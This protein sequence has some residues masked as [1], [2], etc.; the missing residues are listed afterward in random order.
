MQLNHDSFQQAIYLEVI[1]DELYSKL[2]KLQLFKAY[3]KILEENRLIISS[4]K[5]TF[6]KKISLMCYMLH[7]TIEHLNTSTSLH[8]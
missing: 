4:P 1:S 3:M 7:T 5:T 2:N 8:G 6:D